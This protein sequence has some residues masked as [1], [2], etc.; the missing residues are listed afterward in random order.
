MNSQYTYKFSAG[1]SDFNYNSEFNTK[2][3]SG[4]RTPL[5]NIV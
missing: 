2:D 1:K 4:V 3:M 5:G